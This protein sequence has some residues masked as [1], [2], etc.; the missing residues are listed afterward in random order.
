MNR[1]A[2]LFL[3]LFGLTLAN[4]FVPAH[5]ASAGYTNVRKIQQVAGAEEFIKRPNFPMPK[6]NR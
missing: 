4:L 2:L 6:S 3:L 5:E 1:L